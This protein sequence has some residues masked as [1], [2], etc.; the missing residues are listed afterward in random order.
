MTTSCL[1]EED[2]MDKKTHLLQ[3]WLS[4]KE[5]SQIKQK[6]HQAGISNIS[7]Y[8]R[9]MSIDG[10]IVHL[11]V[12]DLKEIV[13]LLRICSNNL[14][15]YARRANESGDIYYEDI[16]DLKNRLE[17]LWELAAGTMEALAA[18]R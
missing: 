4:E 6:M 5:L 1:Y 18:I 14:N 12:S 16:R 3:V 2:Q 7:A 8:V 10:Y 15:Q 9:K 11:D 17:K 13:R